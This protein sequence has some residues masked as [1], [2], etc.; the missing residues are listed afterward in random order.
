MTNI[1]IIDLIVDILLEI[2]LIRSIFYV[3]RRLDMKK[4]IHSL[5]FGAVYGGLVL[6]A[7]PIPIRLNQIFPGQFSAIAVF[8]TSSGIVAV[9]FFLGY[10]LDQF[11]LRF[12]WFD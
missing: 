8:M 7:Y 1:P 2:A 11:L 5:L 12:R 10:W 6:V 9:C 3:H 4:T